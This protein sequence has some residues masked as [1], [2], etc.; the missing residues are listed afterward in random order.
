MIHLI[1]E[2]YLMLIILKRLLERRAD[3][4]ECTYIYKLY[5]YVIPIF[6]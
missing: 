4:Y 5:F 6:G 3:E 2:V 1:H